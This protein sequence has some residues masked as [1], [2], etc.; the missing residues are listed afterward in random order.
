VASDGQNRK[1]MMEA[2]ARLPYS[3]GPGL[4]APVLLAGAAALAGLR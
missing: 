3:P 4:V 1:A 2:H